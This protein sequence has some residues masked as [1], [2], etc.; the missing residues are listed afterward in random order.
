MKSLGRDILWNLPQ[1]TAGA[2]SFLSCL[3]ACI[4]A[5]G[6]ALRI[7]LWRRGRPEREDRFDRP[8]SRAWKAFRMVVGHRKILER[9]SGGL[10]HVLFFSGFFGLFV[11]TC[12]VALEHDFGLAVLDGGFYIAFKLFAETSGLLLLLGVCAAL[13][14]RWIVR[15]GELT[16][17][18]ADLYPLIAIAVVIATGFLVESIRLAATAPA[19]A[20]FSYASNA[21]AAT[22]SGIPL[23]DLLRL[24]RVLWWTHLAFALGFLAAIPYGKMTHL[25][26]APANVFLRTLRPRGALQPIPGFETMGAIGAGAI[27]AFSWKQ[28]LDLDACVQCGRCEARC[29]AHIAGRTLSPQ[30][31]MRD[32]RAHLEATRTSRGQRVG[33]RAPAPMIGGGGVS[34][35][36]IWACTMCGQCVASCPVTIEHVE[37][38]V[39]MRRHLVLGDALIPDGMEQMF[40]RLELFGDP[41]AMGPARRTE[42]ASGLG[43]NV[44]RRR[45][46]AGLVYWVGCAGAFDDRSRAI[47]TSMVKVLSASGVGFGILGANESCCGDFARRAGNEYLFDRLAKRNIEAFDALG[48]EKIVTSCPHCYN[49][50]RNEYAPLGAKFEVV[51]HSAW[52]L[53]MLDRGALRAAGLLEKRVAYHDSCYLGRYNGLYEEPR[54]VLRHI[55]GVTPLEATRSRE[56]GFC[57]GGGGGGLWLEEQGERMNTNRTK[58]ILALSPDVVATACPHCVSMLEDGLAAATE[59]GSMPGAL[60]LAEIVARTL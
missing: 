25:I 23:A 58:E 52:L 4:V 11:A 55:R 15:P 22:L 31:M 34:R 8:L 47:A 37:K 10:V 32:L 9:R 50:L 20:R 13:V 46:D 42:W 44:V 38:I 51:H 6:V 39:D 28:L 17:R 54:A 16:T 29:P 43:V 40:R 45:R 21:V 19:A 2:V 24:H 12:L 1:G 26:A 7:Q 36:D 57:C 35:S 14:R 49:A 30:K 59:G 18:G 33:K 60:D 41:W 5:L 27:E 56:A 53:E 48:V 3:A